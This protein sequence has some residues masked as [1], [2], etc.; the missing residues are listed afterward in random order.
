MRKYSQDIIPVEKIL[1]RI[2]QMDTVELN[3]IL[4]AA[5][6]RH[7]QLWSDEEAVLVLLPKNNPQERQIQ[8]ERT[9]DFLARNPS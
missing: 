5:L 7:S 2:S 1:N 6:H 9:F 3:D 4:L 8:L